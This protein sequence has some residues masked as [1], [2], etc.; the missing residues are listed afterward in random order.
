MIWTLTLT[1]KTVMMNDTR[2]FVQIFSDADKARGEACL[3]ASLF[4]S[5]G[6]TVISPQMG[7]FMR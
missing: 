1:T 6:Y 2:G 4:D 7:V 3:S 5:V